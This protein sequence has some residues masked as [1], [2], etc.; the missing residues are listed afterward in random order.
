VILARL[1]G[2]VRTLCRKSSERARPAHVGGSEFQGACVANCG[3]TSNNQVDPNLAEI[4]E[5]YTGRLQAGETVEV[6]EYAA[7]HPE[8]AE[9]LRGLF[10]DLRGLSAIQQSA[11]LSSPPSI[12]LSDAAMAK[13]VGGSTVRTKFGRADLG[14]FYQAH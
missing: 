5:E 3:A 13:L 1:V 12:G 8:W 6:D 10:R 7:R 4:V 11:V 2:A 9:L 14:P